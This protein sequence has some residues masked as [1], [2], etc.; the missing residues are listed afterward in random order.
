MLC[1][2]KGNC[3]STQDT[4]D[5]PRVPSPLLPDGSSPSPG[6]HF[7]FSVIFIVK[8]NDH[9]LPFYQTPIQGNLLSLLYDPARLDDNEV[10]DEVF[11]E[12]AFTAAAIVGLNSVLQINL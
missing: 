8:I 6:F 12:V 3:S 7:I 5:A 9:S 1:K 11:G 2:S 10:P 4:S